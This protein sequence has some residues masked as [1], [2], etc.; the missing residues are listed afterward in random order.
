MMDRQVEILK[1]IEKRHLMKFRNT[2]E[3]ARS[4]SD[5]GKAHALTN[6]KC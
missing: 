2:L 4:F 5:A 1:W 6:A 3:M